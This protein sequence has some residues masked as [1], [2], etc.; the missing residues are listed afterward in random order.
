MTGALGS[1]LVRGGVGKQAIH[2]D[3]SQ[4]WEASERKLSTRE[5]Q[6]EQIDCERSGCPVSDFNDKEQKKRH[7]KCCLL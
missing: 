2:R 7:R 1:P 3:S 4:V 5:L 6:P